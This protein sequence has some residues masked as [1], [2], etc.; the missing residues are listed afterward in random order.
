MLPNRSLLGPSRASVAF[1]ATLAVALAI[2]TAPES[3]FTSH[4]DVLAFNLVLL[5]ACAAA[6]VS[7]AAALEDRLSA[8][9]K[10]TLLALAGA[11]G[12]SLY[13][14]ANPACLAGP[15]GEVDPE[16]FPVWLGS[17][18]ETQSIFSLGSQVPTLF[19]IAFGY[20]AASLYCGLA[21]MRN[22][23]GDTVRFHVLAIV[24]ALPL[25]FWQIKLIPYATFL[26]I[27]LLAI[28]LA[29][30][31]DVAKVPSS[32]RRTLIALAAMLV[33]VVVVV[34]WVLIRVTVPSTTHMKETLQPVQTCQS[35]A[36]VS[37]LAQ[38]PPGLAL[39]DINLGPYVVALSKLSVL[40]APYHRI[41]KQIIEANRILLA[42]PEEAERLLRANGVRY[43]IT[44]A[45]LDST[46]PRGEVPT[47]ALQKLLLADK[48]PAFLEPVPLAAPT[49]I[50]VWRLKP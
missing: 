37:A 16:L 12:L 39:T 14:T 49:P 23:R 30:P 33:L 28:A 45:G 38:L 6:G 3:M 25:S 1:A 41:G 42:P 7:L 8:V 32:R 21:L 13:A 9:A 46:T 17:V 36:A 22:D 44:C 19:V 35:T 2:T 10:L 4:C 50:K 18:S 15:F 31:P 40:S 29:R 34:S 48:P 24:I 26:P 47:D 20:F 27:P 43:I 11:V 5:A